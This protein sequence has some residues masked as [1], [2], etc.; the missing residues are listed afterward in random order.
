MFVFA[1]SSL[2]HHP[3]RAPRQALP[4]HTDKASAQFGT[5]Y[6][7]WA[8]KTVR[9]TTSPEC[10]RYQRRPYGVL[11][12]TSGNI[13]RTVPLAGGRVGDEILITWKEE[14]LCIRSQSCRPPD[15]FSCF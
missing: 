5:P 3:F 8:A 1:T 10:F 2:P 6:V 7:N 9:S 15:F 14:K 4:R 12:L 13:G 11:Q